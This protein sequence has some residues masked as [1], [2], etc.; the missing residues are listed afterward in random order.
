MALHPQHGRAC[1]KN[2]VDIKE[3]S[4]EIVNMSYGGTNGAM[5]NL[6]HAFIKQNI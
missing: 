5:D 3:M 4:Q 6:I 2:G 1:E